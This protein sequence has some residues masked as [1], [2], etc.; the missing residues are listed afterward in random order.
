MVRDLIRLLYAFHRE[1][2]NDLRANVRM[3]VI[4]PLILLFV[5]LFAGVIGDGEF[6]KQ[7]CLAIMLTIAS[8]YFAWIAIRR[9]FVGIELTYVLYPDPT[10]PDI[11]VVSRENKL[12]QLI[13]EYFRVAGCI[14]ASEIAAGMVL[15]HVPVQNNPLGAFFLVP[16]TILTIFFTLWR[17]G[18]S[19]WPFIVGFI[20]VVSF[21]QILFASFLPKYSKTLPEKLKGFDSSLAAEGLFPKKSSADV[22]VAG[23]AKN[24]CSPGQTYFAVNPED[25]SIFS[26]LDE[27]CQKVV[28]KYVPKPGVVEVGPYDFPSCKAVNCPKGDPNATFVLH[29]VGGDRKEIRIADRLNED[30]KAAFKTAVAVSFKGERKM[31]LEIYCFDNPPKQN[32]SK[33]SVMYD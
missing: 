14:V 21:A 11:S 8:L 6:A 13:Q 27:G 1:E 33:F 32:Q 22:S 10:S 16:L 29:G 15:Y 26:K 18:G 5:S 30:A 19:W 24:T 25:R 3:A 2:L 9:A 17:G 4:I 12:L 23:G 7:V 28:V 31:D 20:I